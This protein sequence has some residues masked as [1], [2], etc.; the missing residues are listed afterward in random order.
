M[1]D[2][3]QISAQTTGDTIRDIDRG[4]AKTQVVQLDAGGE[5]GESLV[6]SGNPLPVSGAVSITGTPNVAVSGT[7]AISGTPSNQLMGP[8]GDILAGVNVLERL[9]D[10]T[11]ALPLKRRLSS[12]TPLAR[13]MRLTCSAAPRAPSR[14]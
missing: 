11:L 6:S 13:R 1:A 12:S 8:L 5:A 4:S 7:V 3:T 10:G 2:N 9:I 14:R